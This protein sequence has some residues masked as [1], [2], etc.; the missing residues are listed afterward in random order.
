MLISEKKH[1]VKELLWLG[2][3]VLYSVY[4]Y[5]VSPRPYNQIQL[6]ADW[7][8]LKALFKPL[9]ET[10]FMLYGENFVSMRVM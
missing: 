6:L 2:V 9:R 5:Y 8:K 3:C 4:Y 10:M 7:K 1:R